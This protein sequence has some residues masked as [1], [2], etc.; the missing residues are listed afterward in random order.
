ML[1]KEKQRRRDKGG[2]REVR[3]RRRAEGGKVRVYRERRK[4]RKKY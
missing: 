2:K 4:I 3:K 1:E